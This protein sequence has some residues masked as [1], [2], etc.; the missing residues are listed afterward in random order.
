MG[1]YKR[2]EKDKQIKTEKPNIRKMMKYTAKKI[3][4]VTNYSLSFSRKDSKKEILIKLLGCAV[5]LQCLSLTVSFS[6]N[7]VQIFLINPF[8]TLGLLFL[9]L[10][11]IFKKEI[12]SLSLF[13]K[14]ET[15]REKQE[16]TIYKEKC[17]SS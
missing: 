2:Y 3:L 11:F 4:W 10:V 12:N 6:L 8:A 5:L 13:K 7:T 16:E 17:S 9:F 15:Q 1:R 14:K